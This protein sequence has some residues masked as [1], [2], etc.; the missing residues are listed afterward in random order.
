[1]VSWMHNKDEK[2]YALHIADCQ[3]AERMFLDIAAIKQS[4]QVSVIERF[5]SPKHLFPV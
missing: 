2:G 5:S 3:L 1:M 4:G